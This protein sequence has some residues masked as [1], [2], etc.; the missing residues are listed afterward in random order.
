MAELPMYRSLDDKRPFFSNGQEKS[1]VIQTKA[2][3]DRWFSMLQEDEEKESKKDATALI[4][5]GVTEAKYK[6]FTSAQR[7][8]IINEM[9][10]W[11]GMGYLAFI[12][13][14]I[15]KA[16]A[17]PVIREVFK[18]YGYDREEREF[19]ILS[20]LQHYGA[21]TPLLDWSYDINVAF[22]CSVEGVESRTGNGDSI[23]SYFSLYKLNKRKYPNELLNIIDITGGKIYP[24]IAD[25]SSFGDKDG[26]PNS[27]GVFYVSDFEKPGESRFGGRG[28]KV[29]RIR[30]H[31]PFTSVYN[32]NIIPQKGMFIFNPFSTKPLEKIFNVPDLAEGSN[33]RL[34]P[35]ECFNIHKDLA[36]YLRRR[37]AKRRDVDRSFIYPNMVDEATKAKNEALNSLV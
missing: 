22:Y 13:K 16:N 25:F 6:M 3:L 27:N 7:L 26:E 23:G 31:K 17:R 37:L 20:L 14:L 1:F 4:Y 24:S 15:D 32:Q 28:E 12:S 19:P 34:G 33:L 21:P 29:L 36:E 35:F 5:R 18:L 11:A 9:Q 8:W 30:N 10:Q 2:E